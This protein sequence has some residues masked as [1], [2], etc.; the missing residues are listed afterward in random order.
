MVLGARTVTEPEAKSLT[1]LVPRLVIEPRAD[2]VTKLEEGPATGPRAQPAIKLKARLVDI[3]KL[4]VSIVSIIIINFS[5]SRLHNLIKIYSDKKQVNYYVK[6]P[7]TPTIIY[8]GTSLNANQWILYS[9]ALKALLLTALSA[10]T[11]Y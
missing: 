11:I 9:Q 4:L 10:K 2:P 1:E 6:P 7:S 5:I 8:R 3:K